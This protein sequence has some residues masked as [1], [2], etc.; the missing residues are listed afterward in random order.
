M[1]KSSTASLFMTFGKF[2]Y[3]IGI[4]PVVIIVFT[5]LLINLV[6]IQPPINIW[7]IITKKQKVCRRQFFLFRLLGYSH[8]WKNTY[9]L[10]NIK[11]I[12]RQC[13]IKGCGEIEVSPAGQ[14]YVGPTFTVN[15]W[16]DP[17]LIVNW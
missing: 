12:S 17:V 15:E 1:I 16:G 13:T 5:L 2:F 7:R 8:K 9:A 10:N 3:G 6:I 14:G 11:L 4:A